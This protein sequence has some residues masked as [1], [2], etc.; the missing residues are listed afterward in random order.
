MLGR[1]RSGPAQIA[2][3]DAL[4]LLGGLFAGAGH[5][6]LALPHLFLGETLLDV[7]GE[8]LRAR[9]FLFPDQ[10]R[11]N[12]LCLRPDF[13]VPVALA[14]GAKG[15]DHAAA[16][17]YQ[18]PVF[19]NQEQGQGRPVEYLQAGVERFGDDDPAVA[20]AKV[21]ALLHRGLGALG[22]GRPEVTIGDLSIPFALL[23]ELDMP[24]GRRAALKR[25]FWRPAR[26]LDLIERAQRAAPVS[27]DRQALLDA[28]PDELRRMIHAAGGMVGLRSI[29]DVTSRLGRLAEAAQDP[30]MP[31]RDATLIAELLRVRVPANEAADRIAALL[32]PTGMRL[33][34]VL[35]SY[36]ARLSAIKAEGIDT[37][38]L[39]YDASFGR[40]LEYYDG[41]VFEMRANSGGA[42]P[43]LP[44]GGR[45]DALTK[46]LG[47]PRAV[48][49]VGGMIR[50]E[51]VVEALA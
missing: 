20:D 11:N 47:A 46:R 44:G 22:V 15:W 13:T 9:A 6:P 43:P 45:Y 17:A 35:E 29:D 19:R 30:P 24:A 51:A 8:D 37:Q 25:H 26:F 21:F 14:H 42:H 2:L 28:G 31:D 38:N 41:F 23:D 12:E 40:N 10:G 4:T 27:A 7:Y 16:Y 18:G 1:P 36:S 39:T 32:A 49:A 5:Q 33:D 50:P 3:N 48:A 34:R